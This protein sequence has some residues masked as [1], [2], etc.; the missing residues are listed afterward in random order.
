MDRKRVAVLAGSCW[1]GNLFG[2]TVGGSRCLEPDE[3]RCNASGNS[4]DLGCAAGCSAF[5][6]GHG[7]VW[8]FVR[9]PYQHPAFRSVCKL[10][11]WAPT[12]LVEG[13]EGPLC[14]ACS[15]GYRSHSNRCVKCTAASNDTRLAAAGAVVTIAVVVV[16]VVGIFLWRSRQL[17]GNERVAGFRHDVQSRLTLPG[18][19]RA[20]D[21]VQ[22]EAAPKQSASRLQEASEGGS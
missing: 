16:P 20:T 10:A 9:L 11:R 7:P 1:F 13:Y 14:V 15:E 22:A 17:A 21:G 19:S 18:R 6:Q 2:A 4:S 5:F 8:E 3:V 12:C